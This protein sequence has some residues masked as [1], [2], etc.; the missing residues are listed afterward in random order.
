VAAML[1][2]PKPS[3]DPMTGVRHAVVL[4]SGVP[5][6]ESSG[7]EGTAE[8]LSQCRLGLFRW[9]PRQP[10]ESAAGERRGGAAQLRGRVRLLPLP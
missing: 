10:G 3:I 8:L 1:P 4:R 7:P 6:T 5:G 2:E 9:L